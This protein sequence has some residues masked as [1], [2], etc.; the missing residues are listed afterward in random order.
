MREVAGELN[1][2]SRGEFAHLDAALLDEARDRIRTLEEEGRAALDDEV[3]ALMLD[4]AE[5]PIVT[6]EEA[7]AA[8]GTLDPEVERGEDQMAMFGG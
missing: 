1:Q 6:H 7:R 5:A 8:A 2:V 4:I 3:E